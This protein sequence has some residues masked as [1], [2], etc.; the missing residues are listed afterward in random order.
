[1]CILSNIKQLI[2][3][4]LTQ[5]GWVPSVMASYWVLSMP[6]QCACTHREHSLHSTYD[7][8]EIK[9]SEKNRCKKEQNFGMNVHRPFNSNST[10][11]DQN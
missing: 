8:R 5:M 3:T 7:R 10:F 1:M 4:E 2:K 9:R 11:I 6:S